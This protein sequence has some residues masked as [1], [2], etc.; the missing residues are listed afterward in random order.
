MHSKQLNRVTAGFTIVELMIALTVGGIAIS[1]LY[2]VG[3]ASTRNFREQNR[4]SSTQ[5]SLRAAMNQIKRDFQRAGYLATPNIELAGEWCMK[6]TSPLHDD[7]VN[8][9]YGQIAAI[10]AFHNDVTPPDAL[11]PDKLNK[12]SLVEVDDVILMGN[13]ATSGEYMGV[14]MAGDG[15]SLT[16]P[17]TTQGFRRD[18]AHWYTGGGGAVVGTCDQVALQTAFA[19]GRLVRIHTMPGLHAFT[20]VTASSCDASLAK[21]ELKDAIP[22]GQ[23]NATG[24]W[25]S[26]VSTIRYHVAEADKESESRLTEI[27]RVAVLRRTELDPNDKAKPLVINDGGTLRNA[28]DRAVL[29]YAVRFNVEFLMRKDAD[30]QVNFVAATE[31]AVRSTPERVR[32][33]IVEIAARTAEHEPDMDNLLGASARLPPFR[34][35]KTPGAARTRALK[36]ELFLPNIA[37]EG[38]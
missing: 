36:A 29:D 37:L 18:F 30:Q 15:K 13:Y 16:I 34:V 5:S 17:T 26:P 23:C 21:I 25:V 19:P 22:S 38:Y 31:T 9:G 8:Q 3:A 20:Q 28:D 1:S 24:G 27:N 4:I 32:G 14:I 7:R 35:L 11:D 12:K 6:G 10:S 2:A 33:V